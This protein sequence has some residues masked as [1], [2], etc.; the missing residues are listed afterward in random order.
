MVG[1]ALAAAFDEAKQAGIKHCKQHPITIMIDGGNMTAVALGKV[2]FKA[3]IF[4]ADG[5]AIFAHFLKTWCDAGVEG[6]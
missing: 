6:C 5:H 3:D 2:L 1:E 4:T